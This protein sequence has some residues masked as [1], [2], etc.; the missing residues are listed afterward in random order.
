MIYLVLILLGL[1]LS[2]FSMSYVIYTEVG[3]VKRDNRYFVYRK[4]RYWY[5]SHIE[6]AK[7]GFNSMLTGK[8]NWDDGVYNTIG[9]DY[10]D[11]LKIA[12]Y[13]DPYKKEIQ[14]K[15]EVI[16]KS[17]KPRRNKGNTIPKEDELTLQLGQALRQND[18]IKVESLMTELKQYKY[19]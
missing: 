12:Q 6:W 17:E 8:F 2:V 9:Y 19:I 13:F 18:Q 1:I 3:V 14:L 15:D 4:T 10:G 5:K 16:W 11:A 7:Y